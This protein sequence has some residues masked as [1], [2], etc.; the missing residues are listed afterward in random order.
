MAEYDISNVS[1]FFAEIGVLKKL[2]KM[3]M[4]MTGTD[5]EGMVSQH[6]TRA[7][8]IAYV[9][10]HLEGA[11][12]E[13]TACIVLFHDNGEVRIGDQN[14]IAARY[15]NTK[16]AEKDAYLEQM[17]NL[18]DALDEKLSN[19]FLEFEERTTKEAI[20]AKDADYLETAITAKELI[21]QGGSKGLNNWIENVRNALKTES[22]K[23]ILDYIIKQDD[24]T[25]TWWQGLKK[26]E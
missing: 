26:L 10:A 20:V 23:E 4:R 8:Q 25:N 15:L 16:Q 6:V 7:A 22:A 17:H 9:L 11:N 19:Y 14:K 24:F 1:K 12:Q 13:R 2:P 21:E 5:G 18:P 3:G